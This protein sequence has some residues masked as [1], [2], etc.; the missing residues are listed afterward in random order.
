MSSAN[1]PYYIFFLFYILLYD[2]WVPE[3]QI[4][5]HPYMNG[6]AEEFIVV[7]GRV[8][9]LPVCD[10]CDGDRH[11]HSMHAVTLTAERKSQRKEEKKEQ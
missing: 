2:V 11:K 1:A 5:Y 9:G 4:H 8:V 10:L 7:L 3:H 6:V